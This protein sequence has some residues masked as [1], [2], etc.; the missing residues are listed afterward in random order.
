MQ[1]KPFM[2]VFLLLFICF[3]SCERNNNATEFVKPDSYITKP[4]MYYCKSMN[5][6]VKEFKDG[7]MIFGVSDKKNNIIYQLSIFEAFSN[8]QHWVLY[9]DINEGVW[10]YDAD[11]GHTLTPKKVECLSTEK[12]V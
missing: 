8:Y 10:F 11:I 9:V 2:R 3:I 4:G 7:S 12:S 6:S 1:N 5:I